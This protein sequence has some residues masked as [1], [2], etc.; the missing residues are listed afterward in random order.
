MSIILVYKLNCMS[1]LKLEFVSKKVKDMYGTYIGKVVGIITDLEGSIES[2]S[3]DC[4]S[5]GIK[6]L[7]YEQLLVQGD[8]VIFIPRW[9][10]DAQKLLREKSLTLKRIKALQEIV[11]D[12]DNMKDD[13][14]LV[15]LKYEKRL[16]D[17]GESSKEIVERLHQRISEIDMESKRIK[18]VL[19]DA[20]LQYKSNEI[21]E[22][23]Y[24]QIT[25]HTNE[26][27]DHVNLEKTEIN[28][29]INKLSQQTVDNTVTSN[30]NEIKDDQLNVQNEDKEEVLDYNIQKLTQE[31]EQNMNYNQ[32]IQQDQEEQEV[33]SDVGGA[34]SSTNEV[35]NYVEASL[36]N[37]EPTHIMA[38]NN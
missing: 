21:T 9:R 3:V 26:L 28:N 17:L 22:D 10:L 5:S 19:F 36:E 20:K 25:M 23:I 34:E 24:Q 8:Y 11:A 6:N 16:D 31:S 4:G 15:Y 13:A 33:G 2:V 29:I 30:N 32:G 12:N 38:T 1:E 18:A 37:N 14:E 27:I 7:P 35:T